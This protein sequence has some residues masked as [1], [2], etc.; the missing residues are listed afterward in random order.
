MQA[1]GQCCAALG[2][3]G[4]K[5]TSCSPRKFVPAEGSNP[6]SVEA[7]PDVPSVVSL[8]ANHSYMHDWWY[9]GTKS[10]YPP[11]VLGRSF[12]CVVIVLLGVMKG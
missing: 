1:K 5:G 6:G 3:R 10:C 11:R 9:G 7:K 4:A 2:A 12:M 8:I